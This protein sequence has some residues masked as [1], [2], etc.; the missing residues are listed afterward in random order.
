MKG[1]RDALVL[2]FRPIPRLETILK[3]A[4]R[5]RASARRYLPALLPR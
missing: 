5:L 4:R 2:N 3:T 1:N